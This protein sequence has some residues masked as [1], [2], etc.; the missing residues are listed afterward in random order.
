MAF[1]NLSA[2]MRVLHA[3]AGYSFSALL[4]LLTWI[5]IQ[6]QNVFEVNG[7][8]TDRAG[9][10]LPLVNIRVAGTTQGT[11]TTIDGEY[12][13][14]IETDQAQITLVFSSLGYSSQSVSVNRSGT[15]DVEL[16]E[17][18]LGFEEVVVTGTSGS[19][20]KRQLG[21]AI[22]TVGSDALRD[23]AALDVTGAMSG[24]IA[25]AQINQTSGSP[26]G[27]VSVKLRGISTINSD[28]EPLYII[29]GVIVDN[30]SNELVIV[31]SG[32]IQNR[33]V[34]LNPR[35]IERIEIIKGAAAA[36]IYG[37][38]ASNGVVQ[39]FT[40]RG[41]TGAPQVT[42]SSSVVANSVR[43]KV[44]VNEA[45]FAWVDPTNNANLERRPVDRFDYQDYIFDSGLGNESYLSVAGGTGETNYFVSASNYYNEGIIRNS[46]FNRSTVRANLSQVLSDKAAISVGTSLTRSFSND[47]PT[48]GPGFFDGSITTLQFVTHEI[49]AT[50]DELGNY[51]SLGG[52]GAAFGNVFQI[53][54]EYD[55][56]QEINRS[57][58]NLTLRLTPASGFSVDAVVGYDNYT[59]LARG[60]KR[61]GTVADP[62]GFTRRG[63]LTNKMVN[64]DLNAQYNRSLTPSVTST[65]GGG[66]TFQYE[67]FDL[68]VNEASNLGPIV[69]TIDGGT[70]TA[71]S[72]II[73][74]RSV[75]GGYLQ[76]TIGFQ[77]KI[78]L[79]ASGR[80]DGSSVFGEEQNSQFY[81]KV[82]G[83]WVVSEEGF[84]RGSLGGVIS[85]MKLRAS[86]GQSGNVTGIGPFER[87]TNY[88]PV[89]FLGQTGLVP[90]TQLGD[91]NI[92]PE[93]QT[94][95]EIGADFALLRNRLAFE[96]TW[97]DQKVEDL[98]LQRVLAPSTGANTRIENLGELTN[99][100]LEVLARAT[101]IQKRNVGLNLTATFSKNSNEVVDIAGPKFAIFNGNFARQWAIEGQP[102]GVF[103]ET[104]YARNDDGS[105]ILTP[106]GLPQSERGSQAVY[107]ACVLEGTLSGSEC[108]G[109]VPGAMRD[110]NG[111]PTGTPLSVILGDASPDWIGSF[112]AEFDYHSWGFRMQ[113]DAIQGNEIY[114]WN[115]RNF[116]RHNYRGGYDYGLEL[117]DDPPDVCMDGVCYER[118]KGWAN[119]AGSGLIDEEYIEDGSFVKL[120]EILVSYTIRPKARWIR[121][122]EIRLSG[123]N[124]LS[125]DDYSG[126]DPEVSVAGRDTGVAGFDFGTVPIPR[127]V[128]AGFTIDF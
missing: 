78:F 14:T 84:W 77:N 88:N 29:D 89:A 115:R 45:P 53:V 30:S 51:P 117:L 81:P 86:W 25:G 64:F 97:Y 120:R 49:D 61:V 65:T 22:S 2:L 100:G 63:D 85:A 52:G 32:G 10:T 103:Y 27:A 48:G 125:I 71:R 41:Q 112:I 11:A 35:D 126:Y 92:R 91:E 90:S 96:V 47:V 50:P 26:A 87:F 111:Q 55:F 34:D 43:E 94:E 58:T 4:L 76:E 75:T 121:Q 6:A 13:L 67:K 107:D 40:K 46:D 16:A 123:R 83:S 24:K 21:N 113:W 12:T 80:I 31:G 101:I 127:T 73:S 3:P 110:A 105:L 15:Y 17:D 116:D 102:L 54:D 9:N 109:V 59:Q 82:S 18:L 39:I 62:D 108:S 19:T 56:T 5:P 42:F 70:I 119:A 118:V 79:T 28:A 98:L 106:A 60:F 36:A 37:S 7:T 128:I 93:T 104:P 124:L 99:T 23:A 66:L 74:E 122:V 38:R 44:R 72:D 95:L 8:V 68:I 114:N 57:T 20:E 1:F 69:E 33:L